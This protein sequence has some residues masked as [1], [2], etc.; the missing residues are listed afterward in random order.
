VK[1][2]ILRFVFEKDISLWHL[3]GSGAVV[4]ALAG[5]LYLW[6][7]I[8]LAVSVGIGSVASVKGWGGK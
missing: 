4:G 1:R 3:I 7:L 6:A 8:A 5:E 2:K